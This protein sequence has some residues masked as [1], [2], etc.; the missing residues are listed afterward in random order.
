MFA[1]HL[2][3]CSLS[4]LTDISTNRVAPSRRHMGPRRVSLPSLT[5][6]LPRGRALFGVMPGATVNARGAVAELFRFLG[7]LRSPWDVVDG[8]G[9]SQKSLHGRSVLRTWVGHDAQMHDHRINDILRVGYDDSP[10]TSRKRCS[11][12]ERANLEA[13]ERRNMLECG[14]LLEVVELRGVHDI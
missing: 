9:A 11:V 8:R 1:V 14:L 12:G 7:I 10:F 4:A 2:D 5:V 6:F 13:L 3:R